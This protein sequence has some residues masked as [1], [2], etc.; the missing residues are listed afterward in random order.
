MSK[1]NGL[2]YVQLGKRKPIAGSGPLVWPT[3]ALEIFDEAARTLTSSSCR[4]AAAPV[5][6]G[7]APLFGERSRPGAP[8][9]IGVQDPNRADASSAR[10]VAR[11]RFE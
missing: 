8:K 4:S 1:E 9:I 10:L 3:Y 5:H 2:R 6:A 7:L 11:R